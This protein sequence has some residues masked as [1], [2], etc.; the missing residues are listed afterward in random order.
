VSE[1]ISDQCKKQPPLLAW[2]DPV[3][4]TRNTDG[5]P[6]RRSDFHPLVQG[7][8]SWPANLPLAEA[9][10]FW[11][12]AGLHVVAEEG[13]GCRWARIQE[14]ATG[15]NECS[16]SETRVLSLRDRER[17]GLAEDHAVP[18]TLVAV[19]YRQ[20]GRLVAWRLLVD[21]VQLEDSG[22]A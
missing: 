2:A 14:C 11:Q 3:P 17:F 5:K 10:L 7:T 1:F 6:G 20:Q 4:Y 12:D 13:G 9:R 19:E 16:R 22:D 15:D 18:K 21:C 8:P